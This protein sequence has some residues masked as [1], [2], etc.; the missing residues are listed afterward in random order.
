M[1]IILIIIKILS[2]V[3]P[4]LI[5][6]SFFTVAERKIMRLF[7]RRSGPNVTGFMGLLQALARRFKN[8]KI[9]NFI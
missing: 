3:M 7:Q 2:I 1:E 4:V 6:S 5:G 8:K 9:E